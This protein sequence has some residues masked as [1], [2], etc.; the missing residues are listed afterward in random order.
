M[1]D[2]FIRKGKVVRVIDGDTYEIE[3]DLGYHVTIT[4][5][6][7]LRNVNV[8]EVYGENKEQGFFTRDFVR[9]KIEGKEVV[10]HSTRREG[11]RRWLAD[12]YFVEQETQ[13]NLAEVLVNEGLGIESD[14]YFK[15]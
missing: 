5:R 9:E 3:I 1:Q 10:V 13:F 14:K 12:I 6:F 2:N 15:L 4:E 8:P 7:R 11:F